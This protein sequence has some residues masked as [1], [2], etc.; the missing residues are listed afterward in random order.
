M[1]M[2]FIGARYDICVCTREGHRQTDRQA[3]T[4]RTQP[5]VDQV[6]NEW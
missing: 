1:D 6:V 2:W 5:H 4:T 3:D